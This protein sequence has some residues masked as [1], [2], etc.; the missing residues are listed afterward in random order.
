MQRQ[1]EKQ[2]LWEDYWRERHKSLQ[3][4]RGKREAVT[5]AFQVLKELVNG[6]ARPIRIIELGCGEGHI[7]GELMKLCTANKILV[8]ECAGID[9]N[10]GAIES[11][12]KLYPDITFSVANYAADPLRLEP[13]DLVL[14]VGTLHEVYSANYSMALG[15]IDQ[16]LGKK[17]VESAL[18]QSARLVGRNGYLVLFDGIEHP[19]KPDFKITTR[20]KST[21]ALQEFRRF[22]AEYEAFHVYYQEVGRSDRI[23]VSIRDFTRYITK[24]RFI[25]SR[26]WE[27]EKRESYQY[28]NEVEFRRTLGAL[29]LELVKL[30]CSSPCEKDWQNRVRIETRG[31]DFPKESVLIVGR[32]GGMNRRAEI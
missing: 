11:A 3:N 19:L 25:N 6:S 7:L 30:E 17:A 15:E 4:S 5:T 13:F 31:A 22:A 10:P 32:A 20:F 24:T 23:R 1:S 18:S 16:A 12:R 26:L 8:E 28:F 21:E 27:V 29:G 14:L 9:N 2:S